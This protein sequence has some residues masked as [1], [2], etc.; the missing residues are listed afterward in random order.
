MPKSRKQRSCTDNVGAHDACAGERSAT[1]DDDDALACRLIELLNNDRVIKKLKTALYPQ[2]LSD[3]ID[4]QNAMSE[5]LI[6]QFKAQEARIAVLEEKVKTLEA[7]A[8]DNEQRGRRANLV[9]T[10]IPEA[11]INDEHENTDEIVMNIINSKMEV[12]PPVTTTDIERSHRLG[13]R[14]DE[15]RNRPIIMRFTSDRVRDKIIRCRGNLKKH[16]TAQRAVYVNED[17]TALRAKLAFD[18]RQLKKR[19]RVTDTWTFNGKVVVKDLH[20]KIHEIKDADDMVR[21]T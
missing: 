7:S 13:R 20:N 6:N 19:K 2:Q 16:N 14:R 18:A 10:G 12:C 17:L 1:G 21:F 5:Q 15:N 4:R 8:D 3:S 9:F 11:G